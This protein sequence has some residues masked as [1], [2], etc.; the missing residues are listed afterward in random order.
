M[1]EMENKNTTFE[2]ELEKS[3]FI[4]YTN[5]GVSMLPL[6]RE[7]SDIL[8]IKKAQPETLK[9]YDIVLF[10]RK[11]IEG[12]GR[13]I[14]HRIIKLLPD[15]KYFIAG[16]NCTSGETVDAEQILGVLSAIQRKNKPMHL[17]GFGYKTY[18][19]LWCAPYHFRFLILKVRNFIKYF[20][21]AVIHK[22]KSAVKK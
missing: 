11:N 17:N 3:G 15:K 14:L 21:G 12:R 16:D 10:E 8:T 4:V 13:Y 2:A 1:T 9:K 6:I 5:V 19:Y 18:V 7:N 22:L 20:F